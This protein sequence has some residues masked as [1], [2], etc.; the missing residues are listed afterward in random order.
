MFTL[1]F[2]CVNIGTHNI[3]RFADIYTGIFGGNKLLAVF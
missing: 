2:S 1:N 3:V